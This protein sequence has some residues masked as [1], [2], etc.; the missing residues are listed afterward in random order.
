VPKVNQ[1]LVNLHFSHF[2]LFC[3]KNNKKMKRAFTLIELMVAIGILAMVLSVAGVIFKV[4]IGS[5]CMAVA[6]AEIMQKLRAIT[7][8]L[9]A[10]FKAV[11]YDMGGYVTFGFENSRVGGAIVQVKSDSIIFFANG[12][13]QS[14]RQYGSG[15]VAGNVACIFYSLLDP[16]SYGVVPEPREKIL[17]RRQTVL[18]ADAPAMGSDPRGEYYVASL[19]EWRVAPPFTD[20]NDWARKPFMDVHNLREGDLVMYMAKGVDDFTIQFAPRS[21]AGGVQWLPVGAGSPVKINPRA[22]KFTFRLYDS[23]GV[24]ERGMIFTHIVYLD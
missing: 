21:P 3:G 20:P 14:T 8:Q 4:S 16:N 6:N 7:D 15:T 17:A 5:Q 12:D 18:T 1:N 11:R 10:D 9:N 22:F 2:A 23:K 24:I 13:F 19:S